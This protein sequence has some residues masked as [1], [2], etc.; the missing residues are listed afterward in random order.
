MTENDMFRDFSVFSDF[1][2]ETLSEIAKLAV[3]LTFESGET[4]FQEGENARDLYGI[5]DGEVELSTRFNQQVLKTDIQYE[6]SIQTRIETI[7]KN[8]VVDAV[9]PGEILGWSSLI[10]PRLLTSTATCTVPTRAFCMSADDL[11]LI[12]DR[13]PQVGYGFMV[14]L[15]EIISQRLRTRTDK[16]IE[17]WNEAFDLDRI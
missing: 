15:S 9:G 6:E 2:P 17:S 5:L 1:S 13:N 11:K 7:E 3:V 8:I 16:L 12:F 14:R 4:I 10:K